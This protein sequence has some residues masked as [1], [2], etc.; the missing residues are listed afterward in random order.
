MTQ[1]HTSEA[2]TIGQ[3]D[4]LCDIIADSTGHGTA[5]PAGLTGAHALSHGVQTNATTSLPV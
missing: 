1:Y 3:P 2:A 4:K 5:L